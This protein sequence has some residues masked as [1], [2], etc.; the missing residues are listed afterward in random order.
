M[1]PG[2]SAPRW[3]TRAS[4]WP[5]SGDMASSKLTDSL[6]VEEVGRHHLDGDVD[7]LQGVGG[8]Q[9]LADAF[10]AVLQQAEGDIL[11]QGR[12]VGGRGDVAEAL[13]RRA[14]IVGGDEVRAGADGLAVGRDEANQLQPLGIGEALALRSE[15]HTSELPSLM[16]I[17]Y[18]VF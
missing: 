6:G 8:D 5:R 7:V 2:S 4:L 1:T 18:D 3:T 14:G 11:L 12:A 16:S 15:E 10:G 13:R 9:V 17:S